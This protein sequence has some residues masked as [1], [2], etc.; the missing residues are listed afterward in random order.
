MSDESVQAQVNA[1]KQVIADIGHV[2]TFLN[3][4]PLKTADGSLF[5]SAL[6]NDESVR[7]HYEQHTGRAFP[8]SLSDCNMLY[9]G[10]AQQLDRKVRI[11]LDTLNTPVSQLKDT[12]VKRML[13]QTDSIWPKDKNNNYLANPLTDLL[14]S[15]T[16][17]QLSNKA[18]TPMRQAA[19]SPAKSTTKVSPTDKEN[20]SEITIGSSRSKPSR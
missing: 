12:Q 3:S 2:V 18:L 9:K 10:P 4:T 6:L 8:D 1:L 5:R 7:Q 13:Q 16:K 17:A 11:L 14:K 20:R 19:Q 15:V